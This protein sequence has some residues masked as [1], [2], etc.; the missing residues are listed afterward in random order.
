MDPKLLN[1]SHGLS[2]ARSEFSS[3]HRRAALQKAFSALTGASVQLLPYEQVRDQLK[4]TGSSHRG[5]QDIRLHDIVG[6]VGRY[7]DFTRSFLPTNPS[8]EIRWASLKAYME[9]GGEIPPIEVYKMGDAY[10]VIDGNHR[11][12]VARQLKQEFIYAYVTEVKTRVP[13]SHHDN[14]E[15]MLCKARYAEFLEQTR[16]DELRPASDLMLTFCDQYELL[17]SQIEVQRYF[18][19][20]DHQVEFEYPRVVEDWYDAIYTPIIEFI[21][22]INLLQ[23]FP[24]RREADMFILMTEHR[25]ELQ[26]QLG[27]PVDPAQVAARLPR[28]NSLRARLSRFFNRHKQ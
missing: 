18:L 1:T 23:E 9:S 21:R 12:S 11:V 20:R 25:R 15:Q 2:R 6:S 13:L 17:L 28:S 3:A 24:E 14:P 10:F 19:W 8:D 7:Q 4:F 22:S 27:E 16:L 26:K 5:A